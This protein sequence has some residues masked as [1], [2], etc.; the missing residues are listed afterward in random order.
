MKKYELTA[1]SLFAGVGGFDLAMQRNGI[2][3]VATVEID[4]AARGVLQ[5]H[6]P[7][8]THFE[9]VTKVSADELRAAGFIP[10]RGIITGGFPCQ[11]LSVAGKRAGLAGKRSG[12]YWQI[13]RL[14]D[15]LSPKYL[16]L[17]N[18]PGLLSSNGGR[19]M[20]VV[21]GALTERGYGVSWRV[22]DAQYFGVAQRR[23]RVFIV[24]CAGDN[25]VASSEI[26]ALSE[27]LRGHLEASK[28]TRKVATANA[29][30]G[31][32]IAGSL[33]ANE[34][35]SSVK[36]RDYKDA[37]DLVIEPTLYEPHHGDGRATEGIANTLAARMG[38]GGNNTPV[39]VQ[40]QVFVKVIRSGARDAEGNLPPEVWR[41]EETNPTLNQ[42]DQG[43]SRTVVA[44][45]EPIAVQGSVVGRSDAAGPGGKGH[46]EE[47]DPMFTLNTTD[48]H[49]VAFTQNQRDEVRDLGGIAGALQAEPGMHQQTFI[50]DTHHHHAVATGTVR[51]LTPT[52]CE[53]LQGFPDGWTSQ[54]IDEKKGL[55]EQADSSR[56]KQM[57]NAVAVP[58]VEWIMAQLVKV[59]C[60]EKLEENDR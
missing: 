20:G 9:D 45:V 6:F 14:V 27:G 50:A 25:G 32:E 39:L 59:D 54:R 8:A 53:R 37:T 11:D 23:R 58:V 48:R 22:L 46:S 47:G 42:F 12:L 51:R 34:T 57:G 41:E 19:D 3:V 36:A 26:L 43:D 24:A 15:E 33:T 10:E 30:A 35:A 1:V 56:Y 17:E 13:V 18:V 55:I 44:I 60:G 2:N 4:K 52:E 21:I 29:G 31:S 16:V 40:P 7:E 38:T 5:H 28:P 49:A